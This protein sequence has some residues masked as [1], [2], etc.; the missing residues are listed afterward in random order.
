MEKRSNM[1][2]FIIKL[3]PPYSF[4][5]MKSLGNQTK[6]TKK[7]KSIFRIKKNQKKLKKTI[8]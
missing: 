6:N 3:S 2:N 5:D 4:K 1:N 8:K 7:N